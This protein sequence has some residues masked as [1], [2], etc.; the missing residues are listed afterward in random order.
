MDYA[1]LRNLLAP[2][3][4]ALKDAGTHAV[5]PTLCEE[6]GL[7]EPAADGSKRERM[8]AS[9][10]AVADADLP[11]IA[12]KLLIRHPPNAT[13]RN[14]IQDLLWSDSPCPPIP[15][16]YRREVARRLTQRGEKQDREPPFGLHNMLGNVWEWVEDAH[17]PFDSA[18]LTDPVGRGNKDQQSRVLRGGAWNYLPD[19]CRAANRYDIA[20]DYRINGFG[21]RVC[22]GSHIVNVPE[23]GGPPSEHRK[24]RPTTVCRPRPGSDRWRR[25]VPS[26]RPAI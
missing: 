13:T 4:T 21:F 14:H 25:H 7:P 3:V 22:R 5:L 20:P 12:Q 15:K 6:L 17:A 23:S 8:T 10:D 26:A 2:L 24:C 11:S 18:S 1:Q 9:F 19:L 16:R